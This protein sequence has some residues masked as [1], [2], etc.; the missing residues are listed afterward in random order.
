MTRSL[1]SFRVSSGKIMVRLRHNHVIHSFFVSSVLWKMFKCSNPACYSKAKGQQSLQKRVFA[2][3][4]APIEVPLHC[5]SVQSADGIYDFHAVVDG[6]QMAEAAAKASLDWRLKYFFNR[7]HCFKLWWGKIW[8]WENCLRW[9]I[10]AD[11]LRPLRFLANLAVAMKKGK[12]V[13]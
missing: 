6:T 12:Y 4:W 2:Y 7:I 1:C 5:D 3:C 11:C 9:L 8:F 10:E 13:D